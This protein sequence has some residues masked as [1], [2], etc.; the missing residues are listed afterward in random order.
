MKAWYF[1]KSNWYSLELYLDSKEK[2]YIDECWTA[3]FFAIKWNEYITPKSSS[4]LPSITNKSLRTLA[5]KNNLTVVDRKIELEE[6]SQFDEVWACGTAA[7]ITPISKIH[8]PNTNIDYNFWKEI[9]PKIKNL[10]QQFIWIQ[11]WDIEDEFGRNV[12]I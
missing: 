5:Q 10:Y 8:N 12:I 3:N 4:I 2:K 7:I 6:L 1:A 9:W 11:N